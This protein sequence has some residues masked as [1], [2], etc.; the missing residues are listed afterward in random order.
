MPEPQAVTAV[1]VNVPPEHLEEFREWHNCEHSTDRLE[2]PG[3]VALHRY[4]RA[5][6]NG[7]HNCLNFFEGEGIEAFDSP[8][9]LQSRNNPTPWTRKCM[10]Y[11][12]DT[13]RSVYRLEASFGG[14]PRYDAPYVYTVRVN[15]AWGPGA[16]EELAAWYR[17]EHLERMCAVEGVLRG[18]LFRRDER[19]SNEKTVETEIQDMAGGR[20]P[21]LAFYEMATLAPIDT[22]VWFE[23]AYGTPRSTAMRAKVA[24]G[25]RERW[26]LDFAKWKG[27]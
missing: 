14:R 6:G 25:V 26:W 21:V 19:L 17:E 5:G 3:Y 12:K 8:Y 16:E 4:M 18:R 7:R 15:P 20:L 22:D 10:A 13:E 1:W 11:L 23:A 27:A 24:E 9:Y 2:G